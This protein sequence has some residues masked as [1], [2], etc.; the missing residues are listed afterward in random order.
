[1]DRKGV[2][3]VLGAVALLALG[4]GLSRLVAQFQPEGP[5]PTQGRYQAVSNTSE[6][7]IILD[8]VT[9]DLYRARA[10]DVKPYWQRPRGPGG[11]PDFRDRFDRSDFRRFDK[12]DKADFRKDVT[13]PRDGTSKK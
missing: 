2:W 11:D 12:T 1:M 4:F 10:E 6:G 5:R 7:I 13:A 9:G 8:T 3:I